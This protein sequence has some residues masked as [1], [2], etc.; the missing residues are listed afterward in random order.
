MKILQNV[1]FPCRTSQFCRQGCSPSQ[2]LLSVRRWYPAPHPSVSM[3][4]KCLSRPVSKWY[5]G[6]QQHSIV[7]GNSSC[8]TRQL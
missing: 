2:T 6:L 8:R 7:T 4:S 5:T 3:R 1:A